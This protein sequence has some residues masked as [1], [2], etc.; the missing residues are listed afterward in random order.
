MTAGQQIAA[1][2]SEYHITPEDQALWPQQEAWA[3]QQVEAAAQE[4]RK[5]EVAGE[6]R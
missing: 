3:R 6:H 5:E 2:Y 4:K 1:Q